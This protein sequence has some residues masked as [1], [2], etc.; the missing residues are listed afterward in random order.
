MEILSLGVLLAAFLL[1]LLFGAPYIDLL[2]RL[3][4]GKQI[5]REGPQSHYA[6]QGTPTLGGLLIIAVVAVLW[7]VVFAVLAEPQP[8]GFVAPTILPF[9]APLAVGFARLSPA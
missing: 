5:R 8:G 2:R 3:R 6:K 1:G 4:M 7:L 9:G